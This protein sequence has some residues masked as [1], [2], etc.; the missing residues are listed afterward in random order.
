MELRGQTF[1]RIDIIVTNWMAAKG[2]FL[3]RVSIGLIFFWFGIL[4]YFNGLSPAEDI[5]VRTI[6]V[7]SFN[8]LSDNLILY[9]LATWEVLIGVGLLFNLF[10]RETLLLLY[11]QMI[12]TFTPSFL[13]P[14]EVF[15]IFPYSLTLEGQYIIKNLVIVSAGIVLGATVRGA[16]IQTQNN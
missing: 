8:L 2:L 3:L 5:A 11:L 6:D 13:F 12:G 14:S 4:K 9:T 1:Q 16:K 15:N 10:L 7:L